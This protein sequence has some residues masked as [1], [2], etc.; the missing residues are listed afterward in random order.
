MPNTQSGNWQG[1]GPSRGG[2]NGDGYNEGPNYRNQPA[3]GAIS[4]ANPWSDYR[5]YEPFGGYS[6]HMLPAS[7]DPSPSMADS[8]NSRSVL[9]LL[10]PVSSS[11]PP[12]PNTWAPP[13]TWGNTPVQTEIRRE[14]STRHREN[15][16][17][18]NRANDGSHGHN[19]LREEA[20]RLRA[21]ARDARNGM[22]LR[23]ISQLYK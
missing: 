11:E 10:P 1:F 8:L 9:P 17:G 5:G 13:A 12:Q 20:A 7:Q 21:D 23:T 22:N 15:R 3:F 16:E 2:M 14:I 4:N 18:L 19:S 6:G